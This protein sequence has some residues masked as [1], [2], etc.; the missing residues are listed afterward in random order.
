MEIRFAVFS[1]YSAICLCLERYLMGAQTKDLRNTLPYFTSKPVHNRPALKRISLASQLLLCKSRL[2]RW[3]ELWT[4]RLI[5]RRASIHN[6]KLQSYLEW[7]TVSVGYDSDIPTA[8]NDLQGQHRFATTNR[9]MFQLV[10]P[11]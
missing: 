9:K 11:P 4:T 5:N 7:L 8:N 10:V 6:R 3:N 1:P 2:H